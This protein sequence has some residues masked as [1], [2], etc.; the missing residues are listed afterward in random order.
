MFGPFSKALAWLGL[1]LFS[2][3]MVGLTAWLILDL[4]LRG[5]AT[6]GFLAAAVTASIPVIRSRVWLWI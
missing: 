3:M 5:A 2:S 4:S 1:T 6:C